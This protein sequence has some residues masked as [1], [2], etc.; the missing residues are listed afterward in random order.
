MIRFFFRTF[1]CTQ[2]PQH[3][4]HEVLEQL[5]QATVATVHW[6]RMTQ[7]VGEWS[8]KGRVLDVAG[9]NR[10][11]IA[12]MSVMSSTNHSD[13]FW[14][15]WINEFLKGFYKGTGLVKGYQR[16]HSCE[17]NPLDSPIRHPSGDATWLCLAVAATYATCGF[18][19][20]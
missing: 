1:F 10:L 5:K 7:R 9:K 18:Y 20:N 11:P 4:G 14:F 15:C 19:D 3:L 8:Q 2:D 16:L 13:E 12:V 6:C 17:Y